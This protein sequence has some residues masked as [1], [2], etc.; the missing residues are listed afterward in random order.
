MAIVTTEGIVL[1]THALGDT[2]KIVTVYTAT[3]D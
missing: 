3:M 2:S 1:K